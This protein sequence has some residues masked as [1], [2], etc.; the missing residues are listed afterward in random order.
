MRQAAQDSSFLSVFD[1]SLN[2]GISSELLPCCTAC[3]D[4]SQAF[5]KVLHHSLHQSLQFL[6]LNDTHQHTMPYTKSSCY[7]SSKDCGFMF[8]LVPAAPLPQVLLHLAA[9]LSILHLCYT[10]NAPTLLSKKS[11][12]EVALWL[13]YANLVDFNQ[14]LSKIRSTLAMHKHKD[15]H[16]QPFSSAK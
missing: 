12:T 4:T 7:I 14:T 9:A 10:A 16:K 2:L 8:S 15:G 11:S 5:V 6:G 3:V 13:F 1:E